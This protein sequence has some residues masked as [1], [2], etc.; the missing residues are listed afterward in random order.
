MA[1]RQRNVRPVAHFR[2]RLGLACLLG[3][4]GCAS[5]T[6]TARAPHRHWAPAYV[7]GIWGKAELDARDDCST[8]GAADVFIGQTWKTL[9]VSVGTLGMYTPREV[10]IRCRAE[11]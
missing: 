2:C 7:F 9:L 8:S 10:R 6:P 11:P 1:N 3:T 5:A 4:L